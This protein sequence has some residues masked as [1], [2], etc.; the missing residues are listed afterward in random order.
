MVLPC[1]TQNEINLERAQRIVKNG[2]F[3]VAEGANMPDDNDAVNYYL[4]NNASADFISNDILYRVLIL[5][6]GIL[7]FKYKIFNSFPPF[8]M[9]RFFT[10]FSSNWVL[11]TI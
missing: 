4:A 10:I 6:V 11:I 1:G 2:C 7:L 9:V 8:F 5:L 3:L